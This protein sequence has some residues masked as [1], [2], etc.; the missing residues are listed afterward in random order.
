MFNDMIYLS[1]QKIFA[2]GQSL[3]ETSNEKIQTHHARQIVFQCYCV[4]FEIF[5]K[6][7]KMLGWQKNIGDK[8]MQYW[9][10]K[11]KISLQLSRFLESRRKTGQIYVDLFCGSASVLSR[12][13]GKRIANDKNRYIIEL[14]RWLQNCKNKDIENLPDFMSK[15]QWQYIRNNP[16]ENPV[17]TAIAGFGKSYCG[18]WFGGY[19]EDTEKDYHFFMRAA[20]NSFLKIKPKIS[21]VC[22][23]N[24]DYSEFLGI[25]NALIYCD[26][27]YLGVIQAW[28]VEKFDHEKFWEDMRILSEDNEVYISEYNAP[29]DFVCV[30]SFETK[31]N[32]KGKD[33]KQI[34]RVENIYKIKKK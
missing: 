24:C 13:S 22:F 30:K 32:I 15:E 18:K 20:K 21:D 9:G 27:P 29:S 6:K 8:K 10:G 33:N 16:E 12:V 19:A 11:T 2:K 14:Y 7:K 31:T 34:G 3:F 17:M 28:G 26:P 4:V 1:R 23:E 5:E 25:K